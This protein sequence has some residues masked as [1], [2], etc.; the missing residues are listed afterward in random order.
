MRQRVWCAFCILKDRDKTDG[1]F[2]VLVRVE[3]AAKLTRIVER[4]HLFQVNATEIKADMIRESEEK[5]KMFD[6]SDIV[7]MEAET[8]VNRDMRCLVRAL[9]EECPYQITTVKEG[10]PAEETVGASAVTQVWTYI[11]EL[12]F[13]MLVLVGTIKLSDHVVKDMRGI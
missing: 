6:I 5:A 4:F 8:E 2:D 10:Y 9:V 3:D 1:V 7:G 12:L 11:G 13:N